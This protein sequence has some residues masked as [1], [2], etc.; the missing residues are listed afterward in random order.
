MYIPSATNDD[1][2]DAS[3][4]MRIYGGVV[5]EKRIKIEIIQ[6]ENV[7]AFLRSFV[8]EYPMCVLYKDI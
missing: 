8:L 1:D 2:D 4:E 5:R 3:G 7:S 6:F